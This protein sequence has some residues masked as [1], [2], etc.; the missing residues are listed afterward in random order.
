MTSPA[1]DSKPDPRVVIATREDEVNDS[2]SRALATRL[3]LPTANAEEACARAD[4][5]LQYI[6]GRLALCDCASPRVKPVS[7]VLQSRAGDRSRRQPLARAL[8]KGNRSVVDA[9]AGLGQDAFRMA[10]LGYDVLAL[11]RSPVL[12]ALL[13]D[14][15]GRAA[16]DG[17]LA[18]GSGGQLRVECADARTALE[19]LSPDIIFLDPMFPEKRRRSALARKEMRML[20][21][22]VGEDEDAVELLTIARRRAR[23]RVV[24]KRPSHAGPLAGTPDFSQDGK[25]VRYDVYLC[26]NDGPTA[27]DE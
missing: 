17:N 7:I 16:A 5:V 25:L 23:R 1:H 2:L 22:L 27:N 20:R 24:V 21:A 18:H 12:A 13:N 19:Q 11:E 15:L 14:A 26:R 8:G 6:D 4:F 9:T 10:V 3:D